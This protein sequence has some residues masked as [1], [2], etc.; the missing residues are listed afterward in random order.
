VQEIWALA[1]NYSRITQT[2]GRRDRKRVVFL[3]SVSEAK[4][5]ADR[6]LDEVDKVVVGKRAQTELLLSAL[7]VSGHVLLE[8]VPGVGKTLL[9]RTFS[10]VSGLSFKRIQFTPDLLPADVT[11]I[12]VFNQKDGEFHWRPGPV[13]ANIVLADEI[14]RATPRT[15][16]SLLEAMEELQVT[17]EGV[18]RPLPSPFMVIATQNPIEME[19]TFPLPEAQLDR[20]LLKVSLGYPTREEEGQVLSRF[21]HDTRSSSAGTPQDGPALPNGEPVQLSAIR[22]SLNEVVISD[23]ITEYIL[24]VVER[25]RNHPALSLG[26]SPRGALYLA[27]LCKALSAIRGRDYV[28]PDDV[29][30]LASPCLSH[31]VIPKAETALRGKTGQDIIAEILAEVPVPVGFN[32]DGK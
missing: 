11:G 15:Q 20:F 28:L 22:E 1:V 24:S 9:A 18:T 12:S 2:V 19:G 4:A 29:K 17:T 23:T 32:P 16:S 26:A 30:Y 13:F 5:V 25:T 10:K 14:N 3:A 8:D 7:A 6:I 31:R 21:V 27:R